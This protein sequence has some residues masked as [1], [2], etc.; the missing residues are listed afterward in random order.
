[1]CNDNSK[2]KTENIG[3]GTLCRVKKIK[4]KPGAPPLQ[5]KNWEG[6]KVYTVNARYVDWVEFERFPVKSTATVHVSLDD[7]VS[8]R[9]ALKGVSITQ[10]P[11]N[12]NDATTGHKL[13]GMSK[14]KLIVVS[15][16]F[17]PNWIYVVL[18]RVRTLKGLF[19]L[20]P[21]PTDCL[22]KFQVPRD[23]QAF[24]RRMRNLERSIFE[25]RERN[26][27]ALDQRRL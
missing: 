22:D 4:L 14:D 25:A 18:S 9:V 17:I 21:L 23:L 7:A 20:K 8:E 12:M 13:Q 27:A 15:W 11:I 1:M 19:L 6:V 26:M 3:N 2:L 5:W 16:S 24:E 10:L